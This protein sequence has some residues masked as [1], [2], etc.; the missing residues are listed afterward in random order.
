MKKTSITFI[1]I[2]IS[3]AVL[4]NIQTGCEMTE[5]R[6]SDED[7]SDDDFDNDSDDDT[8]DDDNSIGDVWIDPATNLVWQKLSDCCHEWDEAKSYCQNLNWG[9]YADWR[10]P[11]ISELRSLVRGCPDTE[12]GGSCRI[13]DSCLD[14][15]C[16]DNTCEGC[17]YDDGPANGCYWPSQL[18]G[19]CYWYLSSSAVGGSG[20]AWI[21][22]FYNGTIYSYYGYG[23]DSVSHVRCVRSNVE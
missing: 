14:S 17:S 2:L 16:W 13:T 15:S 4:Y 18:S 9:G 12:T 19:D 8:D 3:F 22:Y 7:I 23:D 6:D 10:L 20:Y 21:V 11:S 5:N 1:I